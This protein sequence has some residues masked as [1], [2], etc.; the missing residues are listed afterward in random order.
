MGVVSRLC[1]FIEKPLYE[2]G[3]N[4]GRHEPVATISADIAEGKAG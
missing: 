1:F 4:L 2:F 3:R